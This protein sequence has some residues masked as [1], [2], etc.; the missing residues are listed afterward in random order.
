MQ[1]GEA[2]KILVRDFKKADQG[3]KFILFTQA[4]RWIEDTDLVALALT[5]K[6][7]DSHQRLCTGL[8]P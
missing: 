7:M 6:K 2:F 5:V 8:R 3:T 4:L 1:P